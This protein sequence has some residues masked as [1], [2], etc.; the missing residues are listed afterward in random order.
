[1]NLGADRQIAKRFESRRP[2]ALAIR[3][4]NER[5]ATDAG[6]RDT[7]A[8]TSKSSGRPGYLQTGPGIPA[9]K[10][11]YR[12]RSIGTTDAAAAGALG[13][14]DVW[15]GNRRLG[16]RDITA[17]EVLPERRQLAEIDFML[18]QPVT[19]LEFRL[20][21]DGTRSVTL[22]RVELFSPPSN[23]PAPAVGGGS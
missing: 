10:G 19:D 5:F 4:S 2:V 3:A 8:G 14:V 15:A 12:A 23:A 21:I 20:W 6:E 17:A 16:R 1:L 18:D 13:F 7:V 22:E 11:P 9:K